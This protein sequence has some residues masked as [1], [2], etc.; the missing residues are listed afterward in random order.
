MITISAIAIRSCVLWFFIF[1]MCSCSK[2]DVPKT[3]FEELRAK[4]TGVDFINRLRDDDQFNIIEYL[5]FY[6]GGGVAVGDIN[7]DGLIDLYFSS[8]QEPNRL[9]LNKGN[10]KFEDISSFANVSGLGNW[11]TGVTMADVNGDGYLDIF[12]C[13]VGGY[14]GF[15]GQNQLLINNGDLTFEDKTEEY[16]LSFQGFSTQAVFFDYDK[17]GDLDMYL[18]N[19]SVHSV[20]SYGDVMLRHQ[21]DP[22]AG[23]KLYRNDLIPTG[24]AGF[25]EVTSRANIN[26]SQVGYGLG[27]GVSDFNNDGYLDIYVSNDFHENDYLYINQQDG[28][29]KQE[30]EKSMAHSS[31]FSMGNDIGDINNDGWQDIVTLDMLPKDEAIIK[32]SGGEDPYDIFT[33]KLNFGYHYQVAR[34]S[35]QLN[36]GVNPNGDL[37]FSDIAPLAGVE[38]TDWSWGPLLADFDN[39]GFRDFF[40]ANGIVKRPND[41]DYINYISTDSA[42]RFLSDRQM[43]D[44]MPTGKVANYF[45]KNT[46]K[47][48][49]DDVTKAW[50]KSRPTLSNGAAYADLDNDGDLDLIVNNINESASVYRNNTDTVANHLNIQLEGNSPNNFGIGAKAIVYSS[51]MQST[52]ELIP[53]RGWLSSSSY[54]LHFGLGKR[55]SIDSVLVIWPDSYYEKIENVKV[56]QTVTLKRINA[57]AIWNFAPA[58]QKKI[59]QAVDVINYKHVENSYSD[60]E[61]ERLVPHSLS[62]QGPKMSIGDVNG[63]KLEDVFIGNSKGKPSSLFL[64]SKSGA[65]NQHAQTEIEKDSLFEDTASVLFDADGDGDLDLVVVSSGQAGTASYMQPRLYLNDGAGNFS[66]SAKAFE[67]LSISSTCIVKCDFDRDGDIDLFIGSRSV[68]GDYGISPKSYLL[69]NDGTGKFTDESERLPQSDLGM[70]TSAVWTDLDNNDRPNLV[71]VGEWMPITF[72][73]QESSGN[74][75]D[76]T[77]NFGFDNT[78]GWWNVINEADIDGDGDLDFLVGNG[79]LN[80]RFRVTI[81]EPVELWVG[82]IDGNGSSDPIITYYNNHNRYPFISR[83]QL[84][85]Q[86]PALKKKFLKYEVFKNVKLEDIIPEKDLPRFIHKK[87]ETFASVWIE[88]KGNA[89]Y[90]I[91]ELPVEA[92]QFP[93]FA[94]AVYDFNGDQIPDI[95]AVGNWF[96]VQPELGRQDAGMGLVFLGNMNRNFTA[97]TFQQTD[98]FVKGQGRDIKIVANKKGEKF[99]LVSINNDQLLCFKN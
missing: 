58:N 89:V 55:G 77:K 6:N 25:T 70:V 92:Q 90:V 21:S 18:V 63:D 79:G 83:D 97:L 64:Q 39:D 28:T 17:D 36:K 59:L 32:A 3:L 95:L 22:K 54:Q 46:G 4:D 13:G 43:I 12:S 81:N 20:R 82:D 24:K 75:S 69:V 45:F 88:N 60:F 96:E 65:F 66:R 86:V 15:T 87:A 44:K 52:Q 53:T 74:F 16:K 62:S 11:K 42:Q 38:A 57:K 34:N 61:A 91:H 8:N 48:T 5:Y 98:F 67:G 56:N 68:V 23:D 35:L 40:V 37:I 71:I 50:I 26:N 10:F 84:I 76:Q 14:K 2:Q 47:L 72:L 99:F 30:L 41:L 85:K 93:I 73:V 80:S 31:R 19:H 1:A 51:G 78:H 7:N 49:F 33:F 9:F 29:F 27:V 94:F